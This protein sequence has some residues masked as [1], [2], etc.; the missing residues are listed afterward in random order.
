[1]LRSIT[2]EFVCSPECPI[3]HGEGIVCENHETVAWE[4][5]DGCPCGG[6]GAPCPSIA[7][8]RTLAAEAAGAKPSARLCIRLP[9]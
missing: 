6:A 9:R 2:E 1:M 7:I 8:V 4:D 5:G 3:C